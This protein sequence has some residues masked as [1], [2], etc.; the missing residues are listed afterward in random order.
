MDHLSEPFT[1]GARPPN[2]SLAVTGMK[3]NK[4]ALAALLHSRDGPVG[5]LVER[6]AQEVTAA[7]QRNA[8]VIMHRQPNVVSAMTFGT[9]AVVGI[10]NEVPISEYLAAKAAPRGPGTLVEVHAAGAC[11]FRAGR[12]H[13]HSVGSSSSDSPRGALR[14][15]ATAGSNRLW[16]LAATA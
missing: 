10:R 15:P 3:I 5:Q 11:C 8:A 9:E 12:R 16:G 13:L 14:D 2:S 4:Q 7:A 6:R 1:V